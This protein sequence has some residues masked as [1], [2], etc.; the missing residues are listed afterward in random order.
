MNERLSS[1]GNLQARSDAGSA[2]EVHSDRLCLWCSCMC[3]DVVVRTQDGAV[4]STE[5]ACP[6][7]EAW[8]K[9]RSSTG[10]TCRVNGREASLE[11]GILRAVEILTDARFPLIY[12]LGQ[13]TCEAQQIAVSIA[14]WVGA[15]IDTATSYGHA[16]SIQAF[17]VAG[18][19]TCTLGEIRHRSDL[20]I[21]WGADPIRNQPR[22]F[23]NFTVGREGMFQPKGRSGRTVVVV[24]I[25]PTATSEHADVFL[26]I[27]PESD[28]EALWLLRALALDLPLDSF[29]AEERTGVPLEAWRDLMGRMRRANYGALLFGVGLMQTRGR[30]NNCEA[31]LRLTRDMNRHTRF[32][33]RSVRQRGNV[34]GADKVVAWR[35]GYPF[36]VNLSRGYPRYNPGEFNTST[37]LSRREPD[38]AMIVGDDPMPGF[39]ENAM[40][41]LRS[42][43]RIVLSAT[44]SEIETGA[45]VS[46]RTAR[47]GVES[48][49]TVYRMDEV[50]LLLRPVLKSQ[51]PN[52]EDILKAIELS[53]LSSRSNMVRSE[54]NRLGPV[55]HRM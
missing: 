22:L 13:T 23:S 39:D 15:T 9:R 20:V 28:F 26:H 50:P 33:C 36:C 51:Y 11:E 37:T 29:P 14:D 38:A 18:K 16:P 45:A 3:D 34:S 1:A 8:F 32:V 7:G 2:S 42:I 44:E 17:Q 46:F 10:P 27:K 5:N 40:R 35:T 6:L 25:V 54:S 55:Q 49:G 48:Q 52:E 19:S 21:F 43:P 24:D 31:L 4:I 12:G 53:I 41:H 30:H 47:L